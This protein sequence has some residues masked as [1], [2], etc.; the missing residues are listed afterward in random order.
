MFLLHAA[1]L[2]RDPRSMELFI[3][4]HVRNDDYRKKVQQDGQDQKF[5]VNWILATKKKLKVIF[6]LICFLVFFLQKTYNTECMRDTW[7]IF[8]SI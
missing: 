5:V 3:E 1:V 4:I 6:F 2:R 7:T 8:Q